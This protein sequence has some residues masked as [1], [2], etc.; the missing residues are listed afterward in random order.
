MFKATLGRPVPATVFLT[1]NGLLLFG[2]E[3]LRRD[4]SGR[5]RAQ[6]FVAPGDKDLSA[7]GQSD[8]RI[9]QLSF[10]QAVCIGAAQ[11]A[12]FLPGI[13]RTGIT[14][15][16]G[17][18]N[19]LSHEDSARFAFLLTAP[20]IGSAALFELPSLVDA[21]GADLGAQVP[22]ASVLAFVGGYAAV[23]FL[24]KYFKTHTLKPFAWYCSL[25]GLGGLV[26]LTL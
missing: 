20:V 9:V 3:L 21:D 2:V 12:A 6:P 8:R 5:R 14:I 4:G 1:V 13:S 7:E 17:V 10:W 16:A 15:G 22:V 26:Y 11:I 24:S 18:L 23:H 19:G 25:A